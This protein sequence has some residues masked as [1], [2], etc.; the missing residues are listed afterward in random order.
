MVF[1]RNLPSR[2]SLVMDHGAGALFFSHQ[3]LSPLSRSSLG[4]MLFHLKFQRHPII[5]RILLEFF[6]FLFLFKS[7]FGV[8]LECHKYNKKIKIYIHVIQKDK[9]VIF[10]ITFMSF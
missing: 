10:F 2:T 5:K 3:Y 8:Y 9:D 7:V 6:F 4:E 1:V